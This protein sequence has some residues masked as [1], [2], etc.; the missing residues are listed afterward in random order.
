M[1]IEAELKEQGF[2]ISRKQIV[3]EEP[4]K[5]LGVYQVPIK[6]H[7]EVEVKVKVW[8]IKE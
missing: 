2:E 5:A 1:D 7:P 6:V 3:L 8:V 4:I